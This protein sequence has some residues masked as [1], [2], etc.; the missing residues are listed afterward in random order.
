[1][2]IEI[3]WEVTEV[4]PEDEPPVAPAWAAAE[5]LRV[6]AVPAAPPRL[7]RRVPRWLMALAA[8]VV[9][10]GAG[11]WLATRTGWQRITGDIAAL[12]HYEDELAAQGD[13]KLLLQ[14]Q[15]ATSP[16]WIGTRTRQT[17]RREPAPLPAPRLWLQRV[18]AQV[19][20]VEALT[21]DWVRADVRREYLT[22]DGDP[23]TYVLPQFYR[24]Q[25]DGDWRRTEP[26]PNFWGAWLDWKS[27]QVLIRHSE[28]DQ[29]VVRAIGP[30][31]DG[32]LAAVCAMWG[33][34]CHGV[35][36][37]RLYFSS[38]VSS[39][40]YE[41]LAN[42][43]MRVEFGQ[44][45]SDLPPDYFVTA[46]SPQLAGIP[47]D[48]AAERYLID[49]LA[50]RLIAALAGQAAPDAAARQQLIEQAVSRLDLAHADPGFALQPAIISLARMSPRPLPRSAAGANATPGPTPAARVTEVLLQAYTVRDGDTLTGIAAQFNVP[51]GELLSY[52]SIADPDLIHPG[53]VL[54]IRRGPRP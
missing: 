7:A 14:L 33:S 29:A 9:L 8:L 13:T 34:A 11:M 35:M 1:M 6:E 40:E 54:V 32:M 48:A 37:A 16:D 31:L 19:Q 27:P 52:N 10:A 26:P 15:A 41:P 24:R 43:I 53:E 51:T 25:G 12:V 5:P 2:P 4:P 47:A 30:K 50:V 45:M 17:A 21:A 38:Y 23:A 42:V 22:P 28:R 49:Y 18:P 46:P 20:V 3:D 36:P 44:A 39:V